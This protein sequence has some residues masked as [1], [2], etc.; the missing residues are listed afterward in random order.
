MKK[1]IFILSVFLSTMALA[2]EE[3]NTKV[4]LVRNYAA[5][6]L[7]GLDMP[8]ILDAACP[9]GSSFYIE[10]SG[11]YQTTLSILLTAL[12]TNKTVSVAF[13]RGRK[14]NFTSLSNYCRIYSIGINRNAL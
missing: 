3:V 7:G 11:D 6:G 12:T 5:G 4:N 13:E 9:S 14:P 1:I 10:K 2:V 8:V